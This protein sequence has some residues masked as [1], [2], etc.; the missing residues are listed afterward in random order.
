MQINTQH[1]VAMSFSFSTPFVILCNVRSERV[2]LFV[3]VCMWIY[4]FFGFKG[5]R[6]QSTL[7]RKTKNQP[8]DERHRNNKGSNGT[9]VSGVVVMT[10]YK[11]L[12]F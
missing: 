9:T 8:A 7:N 4:L 1:D 2:A 10:T 6:F 3:V 5:S 11:R 12:T